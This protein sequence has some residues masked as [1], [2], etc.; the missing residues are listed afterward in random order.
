MTYQSRDSVSE[1]G[2]GSEIRA[3]IV[4]IGGRMV[5]LGP[6]KVIMGAPP[7]QRLPV[8]PTSPQVDLMG[9]EALLEQLGARVATHPMLVLTG[10][11]GIGKTAL[12]LTYAANLQ[13]RGHYGAVF[14]VSL[15]PQTTPLEAIRA[16][17]IQALPDTPPLVARESTAEAQRVRSRLT[18][19]VATECAGACLTVIDMQD[20]RD[21]HALTVARS[22]IRAAPQQAQLIVIARQVSATLR[23]GTRLKV[24]PIDRDAAIQLLTRRLSRPEDLS[25]RQLGKIVDV[26]GCVPQQIIEHAY[27]FNKFSEDLVHP[28]DEIAAY[29]RDLRSYHET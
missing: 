2:D 26:A 23:E 3:A 8:V 29:I 18:N 14:W 21:E 15:E 17:E 20:I 10:P 25:E 13:S 11:T 5:F 7:I 28:A 6:L 22:V 27:H 19:L 16:L 9:R 12:V 4:N 1:P 24:P